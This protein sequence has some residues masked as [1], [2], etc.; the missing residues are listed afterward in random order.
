MCRTWGCC[1]LLQEEMGTWGGWVP[2]REATQCYYCDTRRHHTWKEVGWA[3]RHN[4]TPQG[5]A[6]L[7]HNSFF[8]QLSQQQMLH[9]IG[10]QVTGHQ[11][12]CHQ[13]MGNQVIGD[14]VQNMGVLCVLLQ[15]VWGGCP[16]CYCYDTMALHTS[17]EVGWIQRHHK[18]T[19]LP[20]SSLF[21]AT[22]NYESH[23]VED[24]N[25]EFCK[26]FLPNLLSPVP[27]AP[28]HRVPTSLELPPAS[29][30][31]IGLA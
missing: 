9:V 3:H 23:Y 21:E 13:V 29:L 20:H 14:G 22:G 26:L 27:L 16:N 1:V 8:M 19:G 5:T 12:I 28:V 11:V 15:E 10:H 2:C 17:K 7:L 24:I 31:C 18:T 25:Y 4:R 6:G 30:S